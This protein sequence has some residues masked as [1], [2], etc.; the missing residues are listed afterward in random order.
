MLATV[1]DHPA[2]CLGY[3][4]LLPS[5]PQRFVQRPSLSILPSA[6][7]YG[8]FGNSSN[9]L[10]SFCDKNQST[11]AIAN[12]NIFVVAVNQAPYI[13]TTRSSF[14][15]QVNLDTPVPEFTVEDEDHLE[16]MLV[17][18]FGEDRQ[19]SITVTMTTKTGRVSLLYTD[20]IVFIHGRGK[21]DVATTFRGPLDK[22]NK[23]VKSATYICR[24]KDGCMGGYEDEITIVVD[25]EGFRGKGGALT[26][27]T[28]IS[29]IISQ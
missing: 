18:S 17:S 15:S 26:Y 4:G 1:R 5:S 29:V 16:L 23:A 25:D 21:D 24:L 7:V 2:A 20:G 28:A 3:D 13:T 22:V 19:P 12:I 10:D 14:T 8:A 27:S 11:I 6:D 9:V